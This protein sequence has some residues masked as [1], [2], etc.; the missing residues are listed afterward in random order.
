MDSGDAVKI[1]QVDGSNIHVYRNLCQAYEAEFS[2]ITGKLPDADGLFPL[3]TYLGGPVQGFLLFVGGSPVGFAAIRVEQ[4]EGAE[5]CEFYIVP[6]LR[7]R[8]LGKAFASRL[9]GMYPGP[10]QVKQL[11][12]AGYATS[13][14]CKV[15]GE[16]TGGNYLQDEYDDP[17]WG[18][19]TRQCFSIS[20]AHRFEG[21]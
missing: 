15:I 7:Q 14:W 9:F 3:D 19:V 16:C 20:G 21:P 13:F 2:T 5:V 6:S 12:G 18:R 10:W 4:G 11:Q 8:G 17:Y 1:Q